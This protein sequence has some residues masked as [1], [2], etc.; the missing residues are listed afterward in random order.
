MVLH[1]DPWQDF[2]RK[3]A[4]GYRWRQCCEAG[5]GVSQFVRVCVIST[6]SQWSSLLLLN[7]SPIPIRRGAQ[8][9]QRWLPIFN[10][11]VR[12]H[13]EW[14][15]GEGEEM[16]AD[17]KEWR[18]PRLSLPRLPKGVVDGGNERHTTHTSTLTNPVLL[19]KPYKLYKPYEPYEACK[20]WEPSPPNPLAAKAGGTRDTQSTPH[21]PHTTP[22]YKP[23]KPYKPCPPLATTPSSAISS[24][25][26]VTTL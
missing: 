24:I 21:P 11:R 2:P 10:R 5:S 17:A 1:C 22:T 13:G 7:V 16:A 26:L 12:C 23:Y 4:G 6:L 15:E 8:T 9:P 14:T 20:P 25:C 18:H 3:S 19:C